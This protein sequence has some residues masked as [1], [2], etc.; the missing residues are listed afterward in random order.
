MY[1]SYLMGNMSEA[2]AV[3]LSGAHF[4]YTTASPD[5]GQTGT[6]P[7]DKELFSFAHVPTA[8]HCHQNSAVK[9]VIHRPFHP[10]QPHT[11]VYLTAKQETC[12]AATQNR[13]A[14]K[15]LSAW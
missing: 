14:D 5:V 10:M 15:V 2:Q 4:P 12:W 13:S 11:L 8:L 1:R 7:Q 3:G 9:M 6:A